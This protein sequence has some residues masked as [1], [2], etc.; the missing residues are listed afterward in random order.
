MPYRALE[1]S[2]ND[3]GEDR[4]TRLKAVHDARTGLAL[5]LKNCQMLGASCVQQRKVLG[6]SDF[7]MID[8]YFLLISHHVS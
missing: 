4:A 2:V 8:L 3:D 7:R 1:W 5:V 6:A